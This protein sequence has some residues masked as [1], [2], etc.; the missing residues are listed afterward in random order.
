VRKGLLGNHYPWSAG[1]GPVVSGGG[2]APVQVYDTE[3]YN[4]TL[5]D[6]IQGTQVVTRTTTAGSIWSRD[7]TSYLPGENVTSPVYSY[8]TNNAGSISRWYT[9]FS[10]GQSANIF[11]H[12]NSL[13]ST[14]GFW[15]HDPGI[16][17]ISSTDPDLFGNSVAHVY[18]CTN[19]NDSI[20]QAV[21]DSATASMAVAFWY[22]K[23][24]GS[25]NLEY[26]RTPAGSWIAL[27]DAD[28]TWRE[29]RIIGS[30]TNIQF[31]CTAAG[32]RFSICYASKGVGMR[33]YPLIAISSAASSGGQRFTLETAD[34]SP[35]WQDQN[36][37]VFA[38][39]IMPVESFVGVS[40]SRIIGIVAGSDFILAQ[41]TNSNY[42]SITLQ[43]SG[44]SASPYTASALSTPGVTGKG[45]IVKCAIRYGL[46]NI[47]FYVNGAL[48]GSTTSASKPPPTT[49]QIG[50]AGSMSTNVAVARFAV[51]QGLLSNAD[52]I[53]LT[54]V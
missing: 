41:Y 31:R 33:I 27:T 52:I 51:W 26:R 43:A 22:K 23:V 46:S 4:Q 1:Y 15:V 5:I 10:P 3:F 53:N 45:S 40:S 25:G 20:Y 16:V 42:N 8:F 12:S 19:A 47:D 29:A 37:T 13:V 49:I 32:D 30:S 11:L 44:F 24:S 6:S 9:A 38:D 35:I 2:A 34:I 28:T 39:T 50:N 36:M 14:G 7:A 54:T 21:N 17:L 18:E 48:L